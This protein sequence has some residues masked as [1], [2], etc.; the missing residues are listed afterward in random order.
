MA[1]HERMNKKTCA[2]G[3]SRLLAGVFEPGPAFQKAGNE[4]VQGLKAALDRAECTHGGQLTQRRFAELIGIAKS[5][6]NDWYYSPLV[7]PI[8]GFLCGLERLSES[9]RAGLLRGL[10]R[11]CFRLPDGRLAHDAQSLGAL[12]ALVNRSRGLTFISSQ[13]DTART[14]LITAMGNSA[15]GEVRACGIDVHS[16]DT[17]VPVSGVLYRVKCGPLGEM[18]MVIREVWPVVAKSDAQL[19]LFNG[20]W[21]AM[22]ELRPLIAELARDRNVIVADGFGT[23]VPRPS[24]WPKLNVSVVTVESPGGHDNR[25]QIRIEGA[26]FGDDDQGGLPEME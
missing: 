3:K 1:K 25:L 24:E 23:I 22:P 4:V 11:D 6:I 12:L 5:T 7:D 19:L 20:I 8:R 21:V 13:S 26:G 2:K 10:C 9:E 14:W 17:F 18:R 16:P 15:G